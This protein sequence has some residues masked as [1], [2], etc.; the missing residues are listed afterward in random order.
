[1]TETYA[2]ETVPPTAGRE[3][4]ASAVEYALLIA[5][6]AAVLVVVILLLGG[7]VHGLFSE[8][9]EVLSSSGTCT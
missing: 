8:T 6:I 9:C 5:G 7:R 4:G 3:R 2:A 1:M